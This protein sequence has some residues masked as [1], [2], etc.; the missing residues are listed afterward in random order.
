V[1]V[2]VYEPAHKGISE[3]LETFEISD[4]YDKNSLESAKSKASSLRS[5]LNGENPILAIHPSAN[6][7]SSFSEI[8]KAAY[9]IK[10]DVPYE[11]KSRGESIAIP[12]LGS[13]RR[14]GISRPPR[15][16]ISVTEEVPN[17]N[18]DQYLKPLDVVWVKKIS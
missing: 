17:K 16:F 18:P 11:T 12:T 6:S 9:V 8:I 13:H 4:G 5:E 2:V 7:C 15:M 3:I 14:H 10:I 1:F